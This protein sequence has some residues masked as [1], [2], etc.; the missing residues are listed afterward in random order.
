MTPKPIALMLSFGLAL[1]T[2]CTGQSEDRMTEHKS[3]HAGGP[4]MQD[5]N[6]KEKCAE[7]MKHH[8]GKPDMH[9]MMHQEQADGQKMAGGMKDCGTMK[10]KS[11]AASAPHQA[12]PKVPE[13][14]E[15]HSAHHSQP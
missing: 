14:P 8:E 3:Q 4:M 12:E 15:D 5:G 7:M 1:L 13:S 6:M 2:G 9:G 11:D 10:G